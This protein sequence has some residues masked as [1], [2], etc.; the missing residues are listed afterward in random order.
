MEGEVWITALLAD[1]LIEDK[2]GVMSAIRVVD[3]FTVGVQRLGAPDASDS[4]DLTIDVTATVTTNLL[5]I[6]RQLSGAGREVELGVE[7]IVPDGTRPPDAQTHA[8]VPISTT[9]GFQ[10]AL[11]VGITVKAE[12]RYIFDVTVDGEVRARIPFTIAVMQIDA[13]A[14]TE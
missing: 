9:A 3:S 2:S 14:E 13:V 8:K 11:A 5:V 4:L 10:F 7:L 1:Q 6:G 12:G